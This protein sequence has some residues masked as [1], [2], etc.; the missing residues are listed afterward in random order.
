MEAK[1]LIQIGSGDRLQFICD[2]YDYN[3]NYRDSY[4]IGNPLV[5]GDEIEI[6]NTPVGTLENC[7]VTFCFTDLYQQ[8]Y[9]TPAL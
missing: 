2:F 5:L 3:G 1:N 8:K 4:K 6:A 9:W 7:R